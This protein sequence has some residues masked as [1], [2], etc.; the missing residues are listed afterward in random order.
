M[1]LKDIIVIWWKTG[2]WNPGKEYF[3]DPIPKSEYI[4]YSISPDDKKAQRTCC[5]RIQED[6]YSC[7]S[8][9]P[10]PYIKEKPMKINDFAVK[11]SGLEKGK[12]QVNIAQIKEILKVINKLVN[13]ELYKL[14]KKL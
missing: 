9:Y 11:V 4:P 12:K 1:I 2:V 13:G 8:S 3:D 6:D 10:Y 7:M 14:I 5:I